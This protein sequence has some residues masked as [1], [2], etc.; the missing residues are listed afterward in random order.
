[1]GAPLRGDYLSPARFR[2]SPALVDSLIG[3]GKRR[4]EAIE[5]RIEARNPEDQLL[6]EGLFKV[7]P[8]PPDRF[9]ALVRMDELPPGW[10]D[11]FEGRAQLT[12][13]SVVE[14]EAPQSP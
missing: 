3:K 1:V 9:K 13:G 11:W 2:G 6:V 5:V 10:S 4:W 14:R 7:I 12:D 8:L